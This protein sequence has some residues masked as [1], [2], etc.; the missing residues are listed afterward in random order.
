MPCGHHHGGPRKGP[1]T[2]S[3]SPI[4]RGPRLGKAD[5]LH[6]ARSGRIGKGLDTGSGKDRQQ[7]RPQQ[8]AREARERTSGGRSRGIVRTG[9]GGK[10]HLHLDHR[11]AHLRPQ[12]VFAEAYRT[13]CHTAYHGCGLEEG[14]KGRRDLDGLHGTVDW[15][16]PRKLMRHLEK[17]SPG[18]AGTLRNILS[19]GT[20]PQTRLAE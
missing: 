12:K 3:R 6:A 5:V 19:G 9:L 20:W 17:S 11:R 16:I 10:R 4:G 7:R 13:Y 14:G 2:G 1:R 15:T 8:G 18:Q